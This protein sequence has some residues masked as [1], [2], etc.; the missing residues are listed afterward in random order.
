M[1]GG[2]FGGEVRYGG[3][4]FSLL[5]TGITDV[6]SIHRNR[7]E[8]IDV[9]FNSGP[10]RRY[11]DIGPEIGDERKEFQYTLRPSLELT[12]RYGRG[13]YPVKE[14]ILRKK[15]GELFAT[16]RYTLEGTSLN[17]SPA[18]DVSL[19]EIEPYLKDG[20]L[21]PSEIREIFWR[22]IVPTSQGSW[23]IVNCF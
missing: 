19:K 10:V 7:G 21:R 2:S 3:E 17:R 18:T 20:P 11:G 5:D 1:D 4:M 15:R 14:V 16:V 9:Q 12:C 22:F 13:D 6:K 8:D 23:G